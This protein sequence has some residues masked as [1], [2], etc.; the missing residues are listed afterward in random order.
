MKKI[1][2][3]INLFLL[4]SSTVYGFNKILFGNVNG[5]TPP[6]VCNGIAF[7]IGPAGKGQ[8]GS[9]I[10]ARSLAGDASTGF[11]YLIGNN[12][13]GNCSVSK[14][15]LADL[16]ETDVLSG[17]CGV[18]Q[19]QAVGLFNVDK[20]KLFVGPNDL[21]ILYRYDIASFTQDASLDLSSGA[22]CSLAQVGPGVAIGNSALYTCGAPS[23]GSRRLVKVDLT[24]F[25]DTADVLLNADGTILYD[26]YSVDAL[27][28]FFGAIS[29]LRVSKVTTAPLVVAN[30]DLSIDITTGS[31]RE[32]GQDDTYVYWTGSGS[33]IIRVNKSTWVEGGS[34]SIGGLFGSI[35]DGA[36]LNGFLYLSNNCSGSI[37]RI[38][39]INLT[40]FTVDSTIII[41]SSSTATAN[42]VF[43]DTINNVLYF[44]YLN[45]DVAQVC[46]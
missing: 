23:G 24:S 33:T 45:G 35:S 21:T 4:I 2:I 37:C 7:G 22:R 43:V 17:S 1:F 14:F 10:S 9:L 11:G 39:K 12:I 29:V 36:V 8:V 34:L 30:L 20:S 28:G 26:T 41:D 5:I 13:A 46:P 27:N 38:R 32:V 25:T 19:E 42:G 16:T 18:L 40:T 6:S 31:I 3:L 44:S 15:N